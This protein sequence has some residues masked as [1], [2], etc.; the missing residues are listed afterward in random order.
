MCRDRTRQGNQLRTSFTEMK[1]ESP[2][3]RAIERVRIT[4]LLNGIS[5]RLGTRVTRVMLYEKVFPD[6]DL[7][8]PK[9]G[10]QKPLS[11]E[12][13]A[14]LIGDWDRGRSLTALDPRHLIRMSEFFGTDKLTDLIEYTPET[15]NNDGQTTNEGAG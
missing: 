13:K 1:P 5:N 12:R 6:V 2:V 8:R 7:G 9:D 11:P 4:E 10:K 14:A 15:P 3:L